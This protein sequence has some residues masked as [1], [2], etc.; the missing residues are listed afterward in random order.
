MQGKGSVPAGLR[1]RGA[2]RFEFE[3]HHHVRRTGAHVR[4]TVANS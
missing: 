3:F 1:M 4:L 2:V